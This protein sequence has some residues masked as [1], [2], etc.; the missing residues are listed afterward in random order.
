MIIVLVLIYFIVMI[1]YLDVPD[2]RCKCY[3]SII[4]IA[5]ILNVRIYFSHCLH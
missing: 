2:S 5:K 1:A 3:S 4:N